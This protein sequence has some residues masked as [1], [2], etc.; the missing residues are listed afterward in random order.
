M[1]RKPNKLTF[2][3]IEECLDLAEDIKSLREELLLK[4]KE[5]FNIM[6]NEVCPLLEQNN[7]EIFQR[8]RMEFY[9]EFSTMCDLICEYAC[10]LHNFA[11]TEQDRRDCNCMECMNMYKCMRNIEY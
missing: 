8:A 4:L 7:R 5:I 11:R 2:D 3:E 6:D 10:S 1:S 9:N